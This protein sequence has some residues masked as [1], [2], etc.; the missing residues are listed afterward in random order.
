MSHGFGKESLVPVVHNE[1]EKSNAD[2]GDFFEENQVCD[3]EAHGIN[4]PRIMVRGRR[5]SSTR[6]SADIC[7]D[8]VLVNL[9]QFKRENGSLRLPQSHPT[10]LHS[11]I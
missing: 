9:L 4:S 7:L 5:R 11:R 8:D 1:R 2:Q 6:S 10:F 3:V